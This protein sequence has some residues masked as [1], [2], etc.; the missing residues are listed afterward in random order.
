MQLSIEKLNEVL[1][2]AKKLI[3]HDEL[4]VALD[5][6]A[7]KMHEVLA[8]ENP[9]MLTVMNGGL[10]TAS[11][12][13]KRLNFPMEMDYVHATRYR[14]NFSGGAI[15]WLHEPKTSLENRVVLIVDD[16]L[17]GGITLAEIVAYCEKHGAKKVYTAVLLDKYETRENGGLPTADFT[18]LKI[19]NHFVFG[20]GLDYHGYWRNVPGIYVV[21]PQHMN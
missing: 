16:I 19:E 15:H 12:L 1:A 5:G 13:A 14:G 20:F 4:M 7:I 8:E 3:S 2:Q 10:I 9:L 11:E 21:A 17:D 6:M 18:G